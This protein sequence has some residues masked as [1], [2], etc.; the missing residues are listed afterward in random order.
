MREEEDDFSNFWVG[1]D[2][3]RMVNTSPMPIVVIP[4]VNY[5][6]VSK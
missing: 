2:T 4:N 6:A 5:F 1:S 3:R